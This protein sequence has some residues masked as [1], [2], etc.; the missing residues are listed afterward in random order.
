VRRIRGCGEPT[1]SNQTL[2]ELENHE[3]QKAMYIAIELLAMLRRFH[4]DPRRNPQI[5]ADITAVAQW[6]NF[7][8]EQLE[9]IA[10]GTT[11][12]RPDLVKLGG[13]LVC[14]R[15]RKGARDN[16]DR[17]SALEDSTSPPPVWKTQLEFLL[18]RTKTVGMEIFAQECI[19][20]NLR[21]FPNCLAKLTN[22]LLR[23]QRYLVPFRAAETKIEVEHHSH[24][25]AECGQMVELASEVGP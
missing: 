18:A 23:L 12:Q 14:E 22:A 6:T 20:Y 10:I 21:E 13:R 2:L 25:C 9:H 1:L 16:R 11:H 17:I 3:L 7:M 15:C 24:T 4:R 19:S 5:R 8:T